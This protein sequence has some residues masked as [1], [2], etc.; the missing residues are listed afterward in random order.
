MYLLIGLGNPG[1]EYEHTRHNAGRLALA[2][3]QKKLDLDEF[4]ENK[5]F[6]S[7]VSRGKIGKEK[8]VA[9]LP[10]TM[11]NASGKAV[12]AL[13]AFYKIKP[14]RIIVLHDD[15]DIAFGKAKISFAKSSGGHRGVDSVR[16]ALKTEN[17][18]RIR[19]GIQPSAKKHTPAMDLVL[20][21]FKP[22]EMND[23][24]KLNKKITEALDLF[25]TDGPE[26]AMNR[27]N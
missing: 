13:A 3:L 20:R 22:S 8:V 12:G 14:D 1:K 25:L 23:L 19:I 9:A 18:W 24:K 10:E 5:K 6:L 15:A 17:F 2:Y 7:L 4:L 26:H 16:K 11:M 27:F 21:M